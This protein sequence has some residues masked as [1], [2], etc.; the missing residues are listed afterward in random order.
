MLVTWLPL[1]ITGYDFQRQKDGIREWACSTPDNPPVGWDGMSVP[2]QYVLSP[3]LRIFSADR[4]V[5]VEGLKVDGMD[6]LEPGCYVLELLP[7]PPHGE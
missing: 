2:G 1:E 7:K 3:S 4:T 6:D 5:R